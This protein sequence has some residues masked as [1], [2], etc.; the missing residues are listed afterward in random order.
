MQLLTGVQ[1]VVVDGECEPVPVIVALVDD[2]PPER[3][4]LAELLAPGAGARE[5]Q[6][7]AEEEGQGEGERAAA[8][9]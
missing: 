1:Q 3:D 7:A 5:G 2:P 9:A 8:G 4:P 6:A